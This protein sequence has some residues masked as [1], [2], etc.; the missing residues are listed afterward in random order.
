MRVYRYFNVHHI[1][2]TNLILVVTDGKC[3]CGLNS[4]TIRQREVQYSNVF[5]KGGESQEPEI[6]D[7]DDLL[8]TSPVEVCRTPKP[9]LYRKRPSL[10][11]N[12]NP[13]VRCLI[14]L[15]I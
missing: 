11:I 15:K 14:T 5:K 1:P 9:S 4:T 2:H 12:Y 7:D 6:E 10:C 3:R 8:G 13:E